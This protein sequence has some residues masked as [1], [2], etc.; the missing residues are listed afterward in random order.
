MGSHSILATTVQNYVRKIISPV[1]SGSEYLV[2]RSSRIGII[3]Y[4]IYY[5]NIGARV[6]IKLRIIHLFSVAGRNHEAARRCSS[7][8]VGKYILSW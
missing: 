7:G 6:A 3:C 4:L 5:D 1:I 2:Q 8:S